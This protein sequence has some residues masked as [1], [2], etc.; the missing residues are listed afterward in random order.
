MGKVQSSHH[1][2]VFLFFLPGV[3]QTPAV[4]RGKK[5]FSLKKKISHKEST[6]LFHCSILSNFLGKI[7]QIF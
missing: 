7:T 4:I 5:D 6:R 3:R 2:A 1:P